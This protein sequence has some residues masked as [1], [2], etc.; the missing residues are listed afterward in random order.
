MTA[1]M[2]ASTTIP[3]A[4]DVTQRHLSKTS[5]QSLRPTHFLARP[6]GELVP[7]IALDELPPGTNIVGIPRTMGNE[8]VFGMISMGIVKKNRAGY[9]ALKED[10]PN[11]KGSVIVFMN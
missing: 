8:A 9:Y 6:T 7:V 2:A 10:H 4:L 3:A 11:A 5:Q 1:R